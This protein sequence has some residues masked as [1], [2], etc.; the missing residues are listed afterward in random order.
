MK[1]GEQDEDHVPPKL[2]F[3]KEL[4]SGLQLCKMPT[5][6]TCN[7]AF[8]LDEE[9]FRQ[10]L[11]VLAHQ[12]KTGECLVN[13]IFRTAEKPEAKGLN[14]KILNEFYERPS[15]IILP[16]GK[17]AKGFDRER[18]GRVVWKIV[19]GLFY[20]DKKIILPERTLHW[21]NMIPPGEKPPDVFCFVAGQASQ[22]N[23]GAIFDYKTMEHYIEEKGATMHFWKTLFWSEIHIMCVFHDP[24]C[25][26]YQCA[27]KK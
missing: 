17:V 15:G 5:H 19:R 14:R 16:P 18:I 20:H 23:Y 25:K 21:I 24:S 10:S 6:A 9:Y 11:G 3:P 27:N 1:E 13:D 12:S 7:R 22:G 2:I 26:C 8:S 4:R